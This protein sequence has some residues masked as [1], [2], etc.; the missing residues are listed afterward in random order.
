MNI[1]H[2]QQSKK[3]VFSF[4]VFSFFIFGFQFGANY[5]AIHYNAIVVDTHNDV[6]QRI[7]GGEDISFR[8]NHGHSDL[9]R[10][11]EGGVDVEMFSI[12]VPPEKTKRSYYE[13]ANEQIDSIMSFVKRNPEQVGF[14]RTASEAVSI[15][16]KEKLAAMLGMEGG[17]P[18][19]N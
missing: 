16:L 11:I 4:L 7:L 12:W 3:I 17:H 5:R 8:T 9:P 6:V 13:Q 1:L 15:A 19:D 18:I 10:F 14:A 2:N